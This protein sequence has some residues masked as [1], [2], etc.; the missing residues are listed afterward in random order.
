MTA[1]RPSAFALSRRR[2]LAAGAAAGVTLTF[3]GASAQAATGRRRL[4]LII[5][6]GA[7]DGLSIAPPIGDPD[8]TALRGSLAITG[9]ALPLDGD[10]GLHPALRA[11]HRLVNGGQGRIAPAI[12]MPERSRS[13]F[14]AQDHL[15]SGGR[16]EATGWMNRALAELSQGRKT[17]ALSVGPVAPLVLR[18]PAPTA[19]WSPGRSV[20]AEGRLPTALQ[21][22]YAGDPVL[23]GALSRGLATESLAQANLARLAET[24]ELSVRPGQIAGDNPAAARRMGAAIAGFMTQGE[25]I[26]LVAVSLDGFDTHA[27]Q[28]PVLA[29]RLAYV[30]ALVDGLQGELGADWSETAVLVV[31]EF[32]RTARVNGTAGTD[33]GTASTA[34]LL[35]GGL[36]AGGII[37][38]WP[39]LQAAKLYENRDVAPSLDMRSLLKGVL[40]EHMGLDRRALE[41]RVFPVSSGAPAL[42]GIV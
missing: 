12:A 29:R 37:G 34:L 30:D 27:N 5:L 4:V 41:Q 1:S 26:D 10:F 21:A 39:S 7:A 23:A 31:T 40:A 20:E 14:D 15:E 35:G 22:L 24:S 18:G 28:A 25:A 38:D 42:T 9:A 32:G 33:H 17:E 3:A 8:Y 16:D 11:I 2:L 13:H 6:R 36:K 19:A